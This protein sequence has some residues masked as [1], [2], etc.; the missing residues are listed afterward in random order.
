MVFGMR[1][2]GPLVTRVK[3]G[4][5][6]TILTQLCN[7]MLQG[8]SEQQRDLASIGLKGIVSEASVS[9]AGTLS[10]KLTPKLVAGIDAKVCS[11]KVCPSYERQLQS[12]ARTIL[13]D[14]QEPLDLVSDSLEIANEVLQ[15]F[16]NSMQSQL[17]ALTESLLRVLQDHRASVRKKATHCLGTAAQSA[18]V[19]MPLSTA[20]RSQCCLVVQAIPL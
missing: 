16:G 4:S 8:K 9:L 20:L 2:L 7:K 14:V 18:S 5:V 6:E 17:P 15:K 10:S 3:E 1:S 19:R 11:R 12:W 13:D